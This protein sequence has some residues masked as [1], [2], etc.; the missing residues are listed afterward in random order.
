MDG[1][2][3][4]PNSRIE[5]IHLSGGNWNLQASWTTNRIKHERQKP[6]KL[7]NFILGFSEHL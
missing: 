3:S 6:R 1:G 2:L 5:L 4:L 7:P